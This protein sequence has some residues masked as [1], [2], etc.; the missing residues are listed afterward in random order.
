[1]DAVQQR[2]VEAMPI[3]ADGVL[4]FYYS[5]G[6]FGFVDLHPGMQIRVEMKEATVSKKPA[7][8]SVLFSVEGR[9]PV[10]V[11][12]ALASPRR[13]LLDDGKTMV[14]EMQGAFAAYPLLRLFLEQGATSS[15]PSR[16]ALLLGAKTQDVLNQRTDSLLQR[17]ESGCD[18]TLPES[19]CIVVS[20]GTV[21][22]LSTITVNGHAAFYAPGTTLS[23]VLDVNSDHKPGGA[24]QTVTVKRRFG[25]HYATILFRRDRE[26]V[27][28][29]IL[30]NGD[31]IRWN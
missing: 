3:P 29:L 31:R 9:S 30:L 11:T 16:H 21:S 26:M 17:G 12:L 6:S 4:R 5:L 14:S 27:S 7:A 22:L 2:L 13:H 25:D 28:K 20:E 23:Q 15:E 24:L 10:G 18:S 19:V 8:G 1:M